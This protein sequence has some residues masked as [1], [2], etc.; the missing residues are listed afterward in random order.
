MTAGTTAG[1]VD[2]RDTTDLHARLTE[3]RAS[4]QATADHVTAAAG[5]LSTAVAAFAAGGTAPPP[6]LDATLAD[7][8][9]AIGSALAHGVVLQLRG[10]AT[11]TDVLVVLNSAAAELSRRL[12]LPVPAVTASVDEL[13]TALKGLLGAG[14]PAVPRILLDAEAAGA[15]APGLH[16]GDGF[17]AADPEIASDWLDDIAVVRAAAG[18]LVAAIH[19]CDALTAGAGLTDRWR[20][21]E[22]ADQPAA[23]TATLDFA[24]LAKL[25]PVATLV[26]RADDGVNLS[27]GNTV[28]GFLIDEWVEVIPQP[29]AATSV[30]YQGDAPAA[31]APQAILLGVAP[32]ISAGWDVDIVTDLVLEALDQAKLRTVDAETAA[33]LG[34]NLPAIVLPD[35]DAND[36]I[37]APTTPLLQIEATVLERARALVKDLG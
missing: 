20:I 7:A 23:W 12:A 15:A 1:S 31:R 34:R 28:S 6:G 5:P 26:V 3:A 21:I 25:G 17:L 2:E 13:T 22:P 32:D 11:P 33:W 14:Q 4:L 19:G 35:G 18:R 30:A 24:D 36:V 16:T 29:V 9:T 37:A 8:R 10:D 27:G